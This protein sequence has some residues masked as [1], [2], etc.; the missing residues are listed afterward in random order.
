[1]RENVRT[2][3]YAWEVLRIKASPAAFVGLVY[4]PDEKSALKAAIKEFSIR[5]E[6]QKRLLVR[7]Q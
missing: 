6:D 5:A 1:M 4:A 7:R 2:K 3:Q